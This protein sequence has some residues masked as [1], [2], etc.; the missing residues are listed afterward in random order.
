[1]AD[2]RHKLQCFEHIRAIQ[3]LKCYAF[4][5]VAVN[6]R[7]K[8]TCKRCAGEHKEGECKV[9]ITEVKCANC[10]AAKRPHDHRVT[11]ESCPARRAWINK[12]ISFLE[13][14]IQSV[15]K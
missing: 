11:S 10:S 3:C 15:N 6:C 4:G 7:N 5:H 12:R 9:H 2:T 14:K 13:R 8:L 1:M